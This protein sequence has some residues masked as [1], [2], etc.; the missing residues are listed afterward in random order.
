M[1]ALLGQQDGPRRQAQVPQLVPPVKRVQRVRRSPQMLQQFRAGHALNPLAGALLVAVLERVFNGVGEQG[2]PAVRGSRHVQ[3]GQDR[4]L[5]RTQSR[6]EVRVEGRFPGAAQGQEAGQ[7]LD[8]LGV[9]GLVHLTQ[10]AV[11]EVGQD[12][13]A[14]QGEAALGRARV[15]PRI[16]AGSGVG[17]GVAAVVRL[18]GNDRGLLHRFGQ[19]GGAGH[20]RRPG[21]VRG[22]AEVC[23]RVTARRRVRA[24]GERLHEFEAGGEAALRV[25]RQRPDHHGTV[26]LRQRQDV[27]VVTQ[28]RQHHFMARFGAEGCQPREQLL[29]DNGEAV[30]VAVAADLA[31]EHFRGDVEGGQPAHLP[32][33]AVRG[34]VVEG[35]HQAEV[36]DLEVAA[37][38]EQVAGFDVE[39]LQTVLEIHHVQRLGRLH[40]VGQ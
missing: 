11:V 6:Q 25:L 35:V 8:S 4:V 32:R 28:V 38:D 14:G 40:Q 30:L 7:P 26:G 16:P 21:R 9:L 34:H 18:V 27:G 39:V 31:A 13:V 20:H 24:E 19:G 1:H 22:P 2:H 17:A 36:G 12:R 23:R 29:V 3:T 33:A 5:D 15:A 10:R 37:D